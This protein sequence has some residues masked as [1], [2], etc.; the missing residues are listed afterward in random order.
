MLAKFLLDFIYFILFYFDCIRTFSMDFFFK[1]CTLHIFINYSKISNLSNLSWI[2]KKKLPWNLYENSSGLPSDVLKFFF[3]HR[4]IVLQFFTWILAESSPKI[5]S[6]F[7]LG[8]FSGIQKF[9]GNKNS[10]L[11]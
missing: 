4:K 9:L 2:L 3:I 8:C 6:D 1:N 10:A 11:G 5:S 7:F